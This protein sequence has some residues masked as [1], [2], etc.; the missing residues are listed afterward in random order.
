M[1]LDFRAPGSAQSLGDLLARAI[2][3]G[4]W[5]LKARRVALQ[6]GALEI[7]GLRVSDLS[8]AVPPGARIT[9]AASGISLPSFAPD[10][11][12]TVLVL[13]PA[14]PWQSGELGSKSKGHPEQV[15]F[16]VCERRGAL[17][18]LRL[19]TE[20]PHSVRC[21]LAA[22]SRAGFPALGDL[23]RGGVAIAGG[24]RVALADARPHGWWPRE[25]VF[26]GGDRT[27]PPFSV[28]QATLRAI[29]RGHPWILPDGGS[30][31]P[32]RFAPGTLVEMQSRGRSG[33]RR[34]EHRVFARIEGGHVAARLW[35]RARAPGGGDE[36]E[37]RVARALARRGSLVTSGKTDAFR[38]VHGEADGLPGLAVDRLGPLLR[39]LVTGRASDGFRGQVVAALIEQLRDSLGDDP[40]VIEVL[41]LRDPPAGRLQCVR[42]TQGVAPALEQGRLCVRER[43]LQFLVDPGLSNSTRPSPGVGL[44]L[45]QR[46]N[47]ARLAKRARGGRWLN[48]FAHTG[49]FSVALLAAGAR[50]VVSV[51]L[52]ASYLAWLDENL[53]LNAIDAGRHRAVRYDGR[54]FLAGDGRRALAADDRFDGIVIDPPTAAAAGR[55]FWSVGRELEP[56]LAQALLRLVPGGTLLVS[57]NDRKSRGG[58]EGLLQR[59]AKHA[60]VELVDLQP[61]PAGRDFPQLSGFPEGRPFEAVLAT[62]E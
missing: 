48:L 1:R 50:E 40:P 20:E 30:D 16:E 45:D 35:T 8:Q 11:S 6:N 17:A 23:R 43:G 29:E 24:L 57:R 27:P 46:D 7:A 42:Q 25:A 12:R 58:L 14:P 61:A 15:R 2:P 21:A 51:D 52:S 55:R 3:P 60:G 62:R 5:A 34:N 9:V 49:A 37:S 28:S 22:L 41:H 33:R 54:R 31:D 19:E 32:S 38:L 59:A 56:M 18:E 4:D 13:A 10:A 39:V 36:V 47:R 44:F 26:A 53:A